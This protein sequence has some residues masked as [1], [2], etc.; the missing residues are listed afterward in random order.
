MKKGDIIT[1]AN[2]ADLKQMLRDLSLAG[3]H[4]VHDSSYG[5]HAIRITEVPEIEYLVQAR[6]E[7]GRIQKAY[8]DTLEEAEDIAAEYGSSF[9]WVEIL[10]G[11][12]GE[13][14]TVSQSW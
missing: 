3:F 9:Q 8:C 11:Y 1:C 5:R 2:G 13:W 4:A 7:G 10:K 14:E 12:A 6:S